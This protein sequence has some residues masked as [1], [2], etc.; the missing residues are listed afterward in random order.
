MTTAS[1]TFQ[2]AIEHHRAGRLDEAVR[3]YQEVV[4]ADPRHAHAWHQLGCIAFESGKVEPALGYLTGAVRLDG[5][6]AT[7]HNNLGE[8]FRAVGKLAEAHASYA[9]AVQLQGDYVVA[10][11]NLCYVLYAQ[12]RATEARRRAQEVLSLQ[13]TTAEAHC[14]CATLRLL[15]GDLA[16]GWE[17]HEWRLKLPGQQRPSLPGSQWD[18]GSLAGRCLF[19]YAEQ[20]L[21]DTLQFVRYLPLVAEQGSKPILAAQPALIPLLEEAKLCELVPLGQQPPSFDAHSALL[22]LPW[23]LHT[24][25]ST[26]PANAAYLRAK[27]ELVT[28]WKARLAGVRGFRVGIAWQG[29]PSYNFDRARSIPLGQFE[30]LA[31]VPGVQ[32]VS[33][34]KGAGVEQLATLEGRFDVVDLGPELDTGAGAF[35][36][37]AAV[38]NNLDLVV[39]SDTS[40]AHLA[41]ALGVPVWVALPT[42]P[43]WRWMLDRS[44]SPW[45]RTMRL[46]RQTQAGNWTDVFAW[47]AEEL[48]GLVGQQG[49]RPRTTS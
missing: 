15:H 43:D 46:F 10:R 6:Q 11:V 8:C 24:T 41:G 31:R 25:L 22:S 28:D 32:L 44:D 26:V 34:Q 19:V 17:E 3:L 14:A 48:G 27:P 49:N 33:L 37:T 45:Y 13:R 16:G 36:D 40:T 21:G 47:I 9:R 29:N 38:M 4:R 35:M 2:Q 30:A 1:E 20:G 5:A 23:A 7:F 18:G 42:L 12:G 39:T